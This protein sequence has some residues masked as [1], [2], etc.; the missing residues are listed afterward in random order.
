MAEPHAPVRCIR[1]PAKTGRRWTGGS[2]G[3]GLVSL[4]DRA[5]SQ[6]SG[7]EQRKTIIARAMA[8]EPELL[9]LVSSGL[10]GVSAAVA[11]LL[12]RGA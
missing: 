1:S 3:L 7:G 2:S 9:L 4:A 11:R 5:F 12:G 8:Q 10:L 6:I